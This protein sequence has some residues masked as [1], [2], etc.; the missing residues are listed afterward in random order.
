MESVAKELYRIEDWAI[1]ATVL[2]LSSPKSVLQLLG[3]KVND[4][5]NCA[6]LIVSLTFIRLWSFY[7]NGMDSRWQ[8]QFFYQWAT[9]LLLYSFNTPMITMLLSKRNMR[10]ETI[11]AVFLFPRSD[12]SEVRRLN[13][14]PNEHTYRMWKL[15]L[16]EFNMD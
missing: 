2:R 9:F 6:S 3:F 14:G 16:R 7:I 10:L 15:I 13:Y 12:V 8:Y 5:G 1:N 11:G 4:I